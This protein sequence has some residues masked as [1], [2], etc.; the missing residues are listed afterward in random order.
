MLQCVSV[1]LVLFG[2][3]KVGCFR[4]LAALHS[5]HL[6]QVPMHIL[7]NRYAMAN[8][9]ECLQIDVLYLNAARGTTTQYSKRP[10]E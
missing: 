3:W 2:A 4:E 5:D 6:R 9:I 8:G 10:T 1:M 7:C